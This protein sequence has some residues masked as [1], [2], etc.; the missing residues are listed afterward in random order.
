MYRLIL[1]VLLGL[2]ITGSAIES[3]SGLFERSRDPDAVLDRVWQWQATVTPTEKIT[4]IQP[5]R[6]TI[7]LDRKGRVQVMFACN[8]GGG[9]FQ[10]SEGKLSFGPLISTRMAC[11]P[12]T[13]DGLFMR[14]LQ[15]ISTFFVENDILYLEL[16]LDGGIMQFRQGTGEKMK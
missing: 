13:Q 11:P 1:A 7:R 10:I 6:Y 12:D 8:S 15:R 5:E 9:D 14:D 4:V 2:L 16:P 3:R